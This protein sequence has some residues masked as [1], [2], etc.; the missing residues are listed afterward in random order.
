MKVM[1]IKH[2]G[3]MLPATAEDKQLMD[4]LPVGAVIEAEIKQKRNY[5]YLKKFLQ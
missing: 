5:K 2:S 3:V 1:L 4:K